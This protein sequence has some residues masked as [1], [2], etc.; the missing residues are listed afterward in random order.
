MRLI[1]V[2]HMK[3]FLSYAAQDRA[4]AA[5]INRALLDQ[6]HDVFFDRDDLPPGEEFHIRIRRAI[7]AADLFVFL[8]SEQA[9]DPGSYTL[10]ELDIAE[11]N[12]KHASGH[13]L[14]VLLHPTPFDHLPAFVKSVTALETPGDLVASVA[15]AVH[16]LETARQHRRWRRVAGALA[17][18]LC[19]A[20]GAWY[21]WST[22]ESS[23]AITGQD[24]APAVLIPAGIVVLGDDEESPQREAFLDAFYLDRFEVTTGRYA[25]FLAATG[26]LQVPEEWDTRDLSRDGEL[27][28]VG[29]N[30]LDATAYCQWA[31]RRLPT[32]A[33]WE[34]AARGT[35]QRRYPWGNEAPTLARANFQNPNENPYAGGLKKVGS[36]PTGQ[37]PYGVEDMAGNVGEWVGD[38]YAE[39][40]T[41]A[42]VRN[43]KGPTSGTTH[44]IRGSGYF[45]PAERL[46]ITKRYYASPD[47]RA[48]DTGF[49]CARDL[50]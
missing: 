36:Y 5:A 19:G 12:L 10:N 9:L 46:V 34:K 4:I 16:R 38:F 49:R 24:G 6:G 50:H 30:W 18:I 37:S 21:A 29:V 23:A 3:I 22:R 15:D 39:S 7:E 2:K 43:P 20:L 32:E 45:D 35:D 14:P 8:I 11:Q 28:V 27:P 17:V 40:F 25:K 1:A 44:V 48:P 33:E 31:G 47:N 26:G 13:L 41:A 42:E